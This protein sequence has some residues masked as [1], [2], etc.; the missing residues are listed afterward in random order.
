VQGIAIRV[1]INRDGFDSHA[2]RGFDDPARDLAAVGNQYALE[3]GRF[4]LGALNMGGFSLANVGL[5]LRRAR[6]NVNRGSTFASSCP[7]KPEGGTASS[8]WKG[9]EPLR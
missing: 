5:A 6:E 1:G 9:R 8:R 7:A 2:A 4:T 3:H